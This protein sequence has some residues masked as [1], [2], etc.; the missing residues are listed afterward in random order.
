MESSAGESSALSFTHQPLDVPRRVFHYF[1]II[2]RGALLLLLISRGGDLERG[3]VPPIVSPHHILP[4]FVP[5]LLGH[6]GVAESQ[7]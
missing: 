2:F 3:I 4:D 5:R 7:L 6:Y 1:V